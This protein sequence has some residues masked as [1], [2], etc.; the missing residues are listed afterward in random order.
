MDQF[1]QIYSDYDKEKYLGTLKKEY[2]SIKIFGKFTHEFGT[3]NIIDRNK[4][5]L[6]FV[7]SPFLVSFTFLPSISLFLLTAIL[8]TAHR[9]AM[10]TVR[11][12]KGHFPVHFYFFYLEESNTPA[13]VSVLLW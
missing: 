13:D 11:K 3:I 1:T 9:I 8:Q 5:K 4:L 12:I 7:V 2:L 6:G 10:L